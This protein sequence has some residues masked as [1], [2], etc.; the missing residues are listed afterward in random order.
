[1]VIATLIKP[2]TNVNGKL[3][4]QSACKM[5]FVFGKRTWYIASIAC[6]GKPITL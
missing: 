6:S 5:L 1:V 3:K 4:M 2:L